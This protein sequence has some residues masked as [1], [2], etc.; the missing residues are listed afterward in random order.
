[1]RWLVS[2]VGGPPGYI[3]PSQGVSVVSD[4]MAVGYMS[5]P[6]GQKQPGLHTHTVAE[7]YIVLSGQLMGWDGRGDEHLAGPDD[8]VYIPAGEKRLPF[9]TL[10]HLFTF[11]QEF[12]TAFG[13]TA[14]KTL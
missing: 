8:C 4:E 9:L 2:W 6:I 5:L 11:F 1:M 14:M 13:V 12:H 7:I 3:N 10:L